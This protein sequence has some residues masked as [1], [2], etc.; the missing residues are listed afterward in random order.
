MIDIE[1]FCTVTPDGELSIDLFSASHAERL[2]GL[3]RS[4][5][6]MSSHMVVMYF[7]TVEG[8][9]RKMGSYDAKVYRVFDL[10]VGYIISKRDESV[11]R[12]ATTVPPL[13]DVF[14]PVEAAPKKRKTAKAAA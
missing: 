13:D 14:P 10:I 8:S 6:G 2:A 3:A 4:F 12:E 9:Y 1:R 11:S 7:Q 5:N